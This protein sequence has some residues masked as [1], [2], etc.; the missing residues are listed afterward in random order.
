MGARRK[1]TLLTKLPITS[2]AT[3]ENIAAFSE[4][5]RQR[6][7][8]DTDFTPKS[9]EVNINGIE[10]QSIQIEI[11]ATLST[12]SGYLSR[13]IIHKLFLDIMAIAKEHGLGVGRAV[14]EDHNR[15]VKLI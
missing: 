6:L 12:G 2:G 13:G 1:R 10:L 4:A 7:E 8:Q 3:P 11:F 9:S 5:I 15:Y 14:E